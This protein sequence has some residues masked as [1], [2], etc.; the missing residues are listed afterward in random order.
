[1]EQQRPLHLM[2]PSPQNSLRA[3]FACLLI[4]CKN[5]LTNVHIFNRLG[6]AICQD[7]R[8]SS[9]KAT[10][11]ALVTAALVTAILVITA[12]VITTLVTAILV[13]T[14]LVITTLV[15]AILVIT[16]LVTAA[17]VTAAGFAGTRIAWH[18][19][20]PYWIPIRIV[21]CV[22]PISIYF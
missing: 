16:A 9:Y 1:M 10:S 18:E 19:A 5:I 15:T 14:A 12:L 4:A 21:G 2:S 13:I 22:C 20:P 6:C 17:P 11:A 8:R 7:H 3:G